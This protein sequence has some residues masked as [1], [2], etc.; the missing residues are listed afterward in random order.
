MADNCCP[1]QLFNIQCLKDIAGIDAS[2]SD[3]T[4]L[5]LLRTVHKDINDIGGRDVFK[6]CLDGLCE[7]KES[8]TLTPED[9]ELINQLE[10]FAA[11]MLHYYLYLNAAG[12]DVMPGGILKGTPDANLLPNGIDIKNKRDMIKANADRALE[13]IK[14][15][16]TDNAATYPCYEGSCGICTKNHKNPLNNLFTF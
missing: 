8:N 12:G 2:I 10:P 14:T 6:T 3:K 15:F 1:C 13:D 16:L 11:Y 9:L 7:R 4:I 5:P